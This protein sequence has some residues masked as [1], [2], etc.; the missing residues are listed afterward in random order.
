MN[1]ESI[2]EYFDVLGSTLKEDYLEDCSGQIYNMDDFRFQALKHNYK[3][4]P[5]EGQDQLSGKE[6]EITVVGCGN[7]FVQS[8]SV[9]LILRENTL[10]R[11][12]Q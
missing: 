1:K 4:W 2:T 6:K 10:T 5:K 9:M 3:E 7:A 11:N 8:I 12:R